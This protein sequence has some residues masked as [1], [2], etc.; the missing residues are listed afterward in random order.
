M[1]NCSSSLVIGHTRNCPH[2]GEPRRPR[3]PWMQEAPAFAEPSGYVMVVREGRRVSE[4]RWVMEQELDRP[5]IKGENVH[6]KNGVRWDNRPENL[7]LWVIQQPAG[8]RIPDLVAWAKEIL[9]RYE[10]E[11]LRNQE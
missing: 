9:S 7:E 6:H 10:P 8:Q 3:S 11:A 4:H 5:L 2:S 1:C